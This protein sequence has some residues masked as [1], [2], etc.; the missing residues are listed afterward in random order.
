[1]GSSELQDNDGYFVESPAFLAQP[2][3]ELP[4]TVPVRENEHDGEYWQYSDNF[5]CS[6]SN[7]QTAV[8]G[9]VYAGPNTNQP[10]KAIIEEGEK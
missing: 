8:S 4:D 7:S 9:D 1:M 6:L 5:P 10:D 2:E 3:L